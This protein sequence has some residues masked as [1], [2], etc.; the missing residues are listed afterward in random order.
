MKERWAEQFA[1]GIREKTAE[2]AAASQ[3]LLEATLAEQARRE[4]AAHEAK[5]AEQEQRLKEQLETLRVEIIGDRT[6][7]RS[8]WRSLVKQ[9]LAAFDKR[10]PAA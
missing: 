6:R 5:I 3:Q 2:A 10:R 1:R 4:Q 7:F 9:A 8:A